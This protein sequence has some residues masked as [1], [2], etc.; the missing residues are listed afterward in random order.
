MSRRSQFLDHLVPYGHL[1]ISPEDAKEYNVIEEQLVKICSRRG[2]IEI[3]LHI[4]PKMTRGVVFLC[5]HF[6][7]HPANR[8]TIRSL[9]PEA[10][11][12]EFKACAV[13]I[14]RLE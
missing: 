11:I 1:E 14:A 2:E 3:P 13:K 6:K 10:K 9:D 4:K 5:F 7:E 8:L 12:P